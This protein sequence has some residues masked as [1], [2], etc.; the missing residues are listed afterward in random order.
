M[1]DVDIKFSEPAIYQIKVRGKLTREYSSRLSGMQINL[2]DNL[3]GGVPTS[4]LLGWVKDQAAL[5]GILNA[6]YELH[7]SILS[8]KVLK[9]PT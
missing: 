4:T 7:L 6:L 8:V 1:T 9:E 2:D 5:S 3:T